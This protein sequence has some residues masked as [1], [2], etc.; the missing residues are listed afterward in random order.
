[1]LHMAHFPPHLRPVFNLLDCSPATPLPTQYETT[2]AF[3]ETH[4]GETDATTLAMCFAAMVSLSPYTRQLQ[5]EIVSSQNTFFPVL[6]WSHM[7]TDYPGHNPFTVVASFSPSSS[8][9]PSGTGL[10]PSLCS[11]PT[12]SG[13]CL[14]PSGLSSSP[15]FSSLPVPSASLSRVSRPGRAGYLLRGEGGLCQRAGPV[16]GGERGP[17]LHLQV[18][19]GVA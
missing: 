1:M 6:C 14:C 2:R 18:G 9:L 15:P 11:S 16:H 3:Y 5:Q 12:P 7:F 17:S 8:C 13:H 10:L 19:A 4:R